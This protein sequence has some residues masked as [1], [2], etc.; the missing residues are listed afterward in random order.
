MVAS[1]ALV[2]A[3]E[4]AIRSRMARS[5][6]DLA[7]RATVAV[8]A[9]VAAWVTFETAAEASTAAP[10]SRSSAA[11]AATTPDVSTAIPSWATSLDMIYRLPSVGRATYSDRPPAV[12]LSAGVYR[13]CIAS[14]TP[15]VASAIRTASNYFLSSEVCCG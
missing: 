9:V 5:S 7:V 3:V 6:P 1:V 2:A 8:L 13:G 11:S 10:T 15:N 12:G 14:V 4:A